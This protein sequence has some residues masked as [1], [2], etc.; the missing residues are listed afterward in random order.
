MTPRGLTREAAAEYVGCRTVSAFSSQVR[1]GL[2][3]GPIPGTRLWDRIAI[4]R[5]LDRASGLQPT[6]PVSALQDWK[7]R[8]AGASQGRT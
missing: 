3:P 4:D 5:A 6:A 2:L 8:R 1:R 7:A